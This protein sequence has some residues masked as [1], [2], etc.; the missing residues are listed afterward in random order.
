MASLNL[1]TVVVAQQDWPAF[2]RFAAGISKSID[3]KAPAEL[4]NYLAL[5]QALRQAARPLQPADMQHLQQ[6]AAPL[7]IPGL[8]QNAA[9]LLQQAGAGNSIT[10]SPARDPQQDL[11][12]PQL[13]QHCGPYHAE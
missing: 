12:L 9:L 6:L 8:V 13:E 5:L 11:R 2:D 4:Q 10:P 3:D 7:Q 1:L